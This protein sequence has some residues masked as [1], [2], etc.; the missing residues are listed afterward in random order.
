MGMRW[1]HSGFTTAPVNG[2]VLQQTA[3]PQ[4]GILTPRGPDPHCSK[5]SRH[6]L[7]ALPL[8]FSLFKTSFKIH[9][10]LCKMISIS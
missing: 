7:L 4:L 9:L 5:L 3:V 6:S 1:T 2:A 8:T 10:T